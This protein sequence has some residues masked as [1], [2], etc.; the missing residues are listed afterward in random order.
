[1]KRFIYHLIAATFLMAN[2]SNAFST[3]P[4]HSQI[5]VSSKANDSMTGIVADIHWYIGGDGFFASSVEDG[6]ITFN[7]AF[8]G[9]TG[10]SLKLRHKEENTFEVIETGN[11]TYGVKAE[12]KQFNGI[13]YLFFY[14]E[15]DVIVR[16]AQDRNFSL[17][18]IYCGHYRGS[19]GVYIIDFSSNKCENFSA[20]TYTIKGFMDDD[21]WEYTVLVT[22]GDCVLNCRTGIYKDAN[23]NV[24]DNL[25]RFFPADYERYPFTATEIVNIADLQQNY[26]TEELK[27]MRNEIFARHGY[28]FKTA[29]MKNHFSSQKWYL[30]TKD[31][32][33]DLLSDVERINISIIRSCE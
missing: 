27:I 30:P 3:E 18:H 7:E 31:N 26:S 5:S 23:G 22:T 21:S 32:V 10:G 9:D 4:H 13:N 24:K 11:N 29:T 15:S 25:T 12:Y 6:I 28:I 20:P 33:D 19:N 17:T 2:S 16:T 14:N 1:M 8:P